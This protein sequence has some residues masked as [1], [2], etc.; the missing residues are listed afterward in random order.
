MKPSVILYLFLWQIWVG[1][2]LASRYV[3]S[4]KPENESG[5]SSGTAIQVLPAKPENAFDER[6][7]TE[8]EVYGAKKYMEGCNMEKN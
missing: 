7:G 4:A 6:S 5:E 1:L 2:N 8:I 3:I